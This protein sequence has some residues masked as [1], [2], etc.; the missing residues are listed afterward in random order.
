[1]WHKKTE[2]AN[3]DKGENA[4]LDLEAVTKNFN[5]HDNSNT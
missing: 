5:A 1:M 4:V 3:S 2:G